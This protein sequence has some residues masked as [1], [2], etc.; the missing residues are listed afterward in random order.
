MGTGTVD[1]ISRTTCSA[2]RLRSRALGVRIM[3]WASTGAASSFTS[4]GVTKSRPRLA[5]L[6]CAVLYSA[7]PALGLAPSE[8]PLFCRVAWTM[9]TTYPRT[10][11]STRTEDTALIRVHLSQLR[12]KLGP[13]A[14]VI[15]TVRG[16][17]YRLSPV[18]ANLTRLADEENLRQTA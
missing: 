17:G 11:S 3:R 10:A 4:S 1:K 7:R 16:Q 8:R 15:T 13:T 12:R 9:A 18:P 6:A 5:A 14:A 2:E